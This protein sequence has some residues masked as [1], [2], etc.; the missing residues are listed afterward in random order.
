MH[1]KLV[2]RLSGTDAYGDAYAEEV[3]HFVWRQHLGEA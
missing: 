3:R 1:D 2:T